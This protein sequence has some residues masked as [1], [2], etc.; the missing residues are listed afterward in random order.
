[1]EKKY[2]QS[3]G[4]LNQSEAYN[5]EVKDEFKEELPFV[6]DESKSFLETA[7]PRR[8][9]LK[10]LGFSTAAAAVAASCEMPVKKAIPFANKPED[11]VP[12]IS[13][14][15][16][17]T[18]VQD[19]DVVSVLAKVRDG[20]PIKIEGNDL[21]PIT[22]GGT[23]ARVQASVLD[24][25]DTARLRFPTI[26]GKEVTFEAIDKAL[27]GAV[28]GNVVILTSTITSPST[29][30]IIA[31]F[32]TKNPGSRHVTYDAVSYSAMLQANEATYGVRGIPSYHFENAKAIV[33]LGA[34][35]LGTWLSPVEFSKQYAA[36]KKID[37]KN[38]SMSKHI[39]FE[40]VASMTGSNA[41]EK[42]L[43]RPSETGAIAAALLSAVNGQGVNGISDAKLKAGIEKA[44]KTL[45]E[46]KGAALVV[47]GSNDVNVQIIVNAINNAIGAGGT[48]INWGVMNHQRAGVD[49]DFVRLVE[50]MNAGIVNT[51]LV[52]GANPA[53]TWFDAE[54]FK[55]GLKKVRTTVSFASKMDETAELCK[56]VVPD[57]HYLESWG[58]AE[59]KTGHFS[60][61]QP[62]IYPLFKTRQWQDSLLKWSGNTADYLAYLKN[63]WSTKLGGQTGWDKALQDG[64]ISLGESATKP[65]SFNGASVGA[66]V[67]AATSG[68]K[69]GKYEL[70]LYEKVGIGAG[71]GASN[72]WLQE[73]PDPVTRATWDNY[74]I[75]SPPLARTIL[76][77]DLNNGG[78][79]DAYEV[80]PPKKVV[81]VVANGKEISLPVLIIPGTHP[82]TIGIAVGYG[83]SNNIGKAAA[84]VGQNAFPLAS[85][86]NGVV[87]YTN[88]SVEIT[89]TGEKY[90]VALTQTHNRYDTTQGNRT[91]VMKELTLADYKK[92][93]T[94]IREE[95][96][97]ELKPW[98]GLE[99]FESQGTIYPVYDRPGIKWGMSV[100]LN[101]CTGCGACVVA[102]NAENNVSVVGKPEV[103]RGHE[104]HWLRI[105]RY[106]SGDMDN[107][108]VVFQPLM[109]QHCDNAP[110]ENVCPVA[111]TNHSSEG[112][113]QMTYNR[114]IGTR[115]CANNCPYKVRRF[116]WSDYT[117]SDS[118]GNNQEGIVNDVVLNMNDDL[119][120]MVLNP[121]VTV[122]SRG[123]IEKC[124]F[125]VQRL[126]ES[127]LKAKKESRP[128]V[129]SDI[130]VACQQACPTNAITFGNANDKHSAITMVRTENPNRQFYVLEQLHVLP[131][132]TYLAK[133]RNTES[134]HGEGKHETKKEAEHA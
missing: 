13:N 62:T 84:G 82:D 14:Y 28:G 15:Y 24:L 30:A 72:P 94:E 83:R 85:I 39:H 53:Y 113:N 105:D 12:G 130:K 36:G 25:Y 3:F 120:R 41:D 35:F 78:Q 133:V 87:S 49:A 126:Q 97:H 122:R 123:V 79:A 8:D 129:D 128:L 32:L 88:T 102:C 43:H 1:M 69:G 109:C 2:W 70:V 23:S 51:L 20:R 33:S 118:F 50:D 99:K 76:D 27:A 17:T 66:A 112:I 71:Q 107:P 134:A 4:E 59:A 73:L 5:K 121:D 11:I 68:K 91:E 115:Y 125:C 29:K 103:L 18:Y 21:S 75:V 40:S 45:N 37:E 104:M 74:V 110:C 52:Y 131:G 65:G 7:A 54:K 10:Y 57:H 6:G 34:D 132:V 95:R 86:S 111:A 98:G 77:I 90:P 58:D 89:V 114:C 117:G 116:N 42:Y 63:F 92:H 106:Y 56:F 127:K 26:D 16:A 64:V 119:T 46:N 80:N 101:T 67:A 48:T 47:A 22:K 61:I 31:E 81:K 100:D 38:P 60:F 19:G 44:A 124:S 96:D 55:A 93:P 108:N 9:F